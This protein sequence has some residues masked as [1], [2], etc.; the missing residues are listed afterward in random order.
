MGPEARGD[1]RGAAMDRVEAISVHVIGK[2]AGTADARNE[3]IVLAGNAQLGQH[4][5][6]LGQN[7]VV[8]ATGTPA[9][10]VIADEIFAGL[11]LR[12]VSGRWRHF[13]PHGTKK[14]AL[15]RPE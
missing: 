13:L 7:G 8:S 5:L 11:I 14:E 4:V 6:K 10:V 2:T 1:G 9:H 15:R 3:H 12:R